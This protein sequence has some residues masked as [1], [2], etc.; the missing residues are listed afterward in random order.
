MK[1]TKALLVNTDLYLNQDIL[2][3]PNDGFDLGLMNTSYQVKI[4]SN[5]TVDVFN[6]SEKD[7]IMGNLL[8]HNKC[9]HGTILICH[10]YWQ[11]IGMPEKIIMFYDNEKILISNV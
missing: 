3:H 7:F 8:L 1:S 9:K 4:F 11:K 10:K 5:V 2:L 6:N